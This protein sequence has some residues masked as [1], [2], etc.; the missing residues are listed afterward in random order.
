MKTHRYQRMFYRDWINAEDLHITDFVASQTDLQVMT[1]KKLDMA[2]ADERIR[3]MR[4]DIEQYIN[5]DS[6]FLHSNGPLTVSNNAPDI[7]REMALQS[8]LA[9]AGPMTTVAGAIAHFLGQDLS[10]KGHKDVIVE[11]THNIY[12]KTSKTRRVSIYNGKSKLW[13][14]LRLEVRPKETP[15]GICIYSSAKNHSLG[16]GCADSVVV[17]AKNALLANAVANLA[18]SRIHARKDLQPAVDFA[19]RIKGIIGVVVILKS[20]LISWGRIRFVK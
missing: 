13:N 18:G 12:I 5:N 7:V 15:L 14:K 1:S 4:I 8:A 17:V 6:R 19:Q 20:D 9:G 2:F 10:R 11:N 16:R 3:A